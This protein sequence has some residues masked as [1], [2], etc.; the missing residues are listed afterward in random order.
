MSDISDRAKRLGN[1]TERSDWLDHAARAGLV[2]FG[3]VHLVVGW[4]AVQLAFGDR[5]GS[6][7][8]TGAI[9]Q[10]AEQ[11]FGAVLVW[12]VAI[13]M[14]LLAAWQAV[15]AAVGHRDREGAT[16][17]RKRLTSA[18]KAVIYAVIGTSALKIALGERTG[19][20]EKSTDSLTAQIMDLPGGQVLVGLVGLGIIV[21]GGALVYK[22][23][24]DRFLRD[25]DS[26][27][28]RGA[29]GSAYT[30]LGR[31]GYT[32]KGVAL[33][34]VGALFVWAAITHEPDKSGG[35]DQ[36][37]TQVLDQPF[38]PAL[39]TAIGVGIACFGVFCFAW[40]RHLDR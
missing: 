14:Y 30:W 25:I 33:G 7:N 21:V 40:A 13:G 34:V 16:R 29:T 20:S 9:R 17:V 1:R 27:G 15:E 12:A 24:T 28:K 10:L 3:V 38:G 4:L 6:T 39:L 2:T 37:L 5:E 22:G 19:S 8:T 31:V 26:E 23:L 36:A 35:L 32:A 18:G 11:P